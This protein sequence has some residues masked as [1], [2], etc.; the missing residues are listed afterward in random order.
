MLVILDATTTDKSIAG[1]EE[2][3]LATSDDL[4]VEDGILT[5]GFVGK[6]VSYEN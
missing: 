5:I 4:R 6:N 3:G 1:P 2:S